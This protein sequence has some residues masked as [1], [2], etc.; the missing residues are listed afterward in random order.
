MVIFLN[1]YLFNC[2]IHC[3]NSQLIW[4]LNP[5]VFIPLSVSML[6]LHPSVTWSPCSELGH[7]GSAMLWGEVFFWLEEEHIIHSRHCGFTSLSPL[8]PLGINPLPFRYNNKPPATEEELLFR[9]PQNTTAVSVTSWSL[10]REIPQQFLRITLT[11][12][13]KLCT[14]LHLHTRKLFY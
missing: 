8:L 12:N 11:Q 3:K 9:P 13:L 1:M 2:M 5:I 6:C 4:E 10:W 14:K 7:M